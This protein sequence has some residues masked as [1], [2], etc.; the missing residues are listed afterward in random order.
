[1]RTTY[2]HAATNLPMAEERRERKRYK[3]DCPVTVLT[4]GRGRKRTIGRGW[5]YDI[6]DKGARFVVEQPLHTGDRI[7]LE[8]HFLNP[9]GEV[10]NI[11]YPATVKRV[12]PGPAHE[13]AVTFSRGGS[14]VRRKESGEKSFRRIQ[15]NGGSHWIN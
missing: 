10:T 1:M 3:I 2:S 4:P 8:V 6:S 11:R 14:F 7:S 5:L 12:S 13:T 9:D 15:M